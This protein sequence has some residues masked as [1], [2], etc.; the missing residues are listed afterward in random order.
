[1]LQLNVCPGT[2]YSASFDRV[3]HSRREFK[4]VLRATQDT[5]RP[6]QEYEPVIP[7]EKRKNRY[8][9]QKPV[10]GVRFSRPVESKD[11]RER[12]KDTEAF[13]RQ[14]GIVKP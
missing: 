6:K 7:R 11:P 9:G 5:A 10:E 1:V 14:N 8:R 12:A 4:E 13:V 2:Q 3:I